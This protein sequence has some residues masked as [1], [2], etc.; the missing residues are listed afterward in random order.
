M[1]MKP[2]TDDMSSPPTRDTPS[3]SSLPE[4]DTRLCPD[5][6]RQ[7]G[8]VLKTYLLQNAP[9]YRHLDALRQKVCTSMLLALE[10]CSQR[11]R[12]RASRGFKVCSLSCFILGMG[13]QGWRCVFRKA[14]A[15]SGPPGWKHG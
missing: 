13:E 12:A 10:Y 4:T 1:S 7:S 15:A 5:A 3:V 8:P 2:T 11:K 9:E 14:E 6:S